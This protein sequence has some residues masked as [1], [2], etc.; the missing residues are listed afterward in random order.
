MTSL[1]F[2]AN[3]LFTIIKPKKFI[4]VETIYTKMPKYKQ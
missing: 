3:N 4:Q 2:Y 1:F